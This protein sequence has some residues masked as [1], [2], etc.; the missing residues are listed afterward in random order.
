V[1]ARLRDLDDELLAWVGRGTASGAALCDTLGLCAQHGALLAERAEPAALARLLAEASRRALGLLADDRRSHERLTALVF[2]AEHACG[3]C[4]LRSH[5]LALEVH[6]IARDDPP[7]PVC[8]AHYPSLVHALNQS[9]LHRLVL[10]QRARWDELA[11]QLSADGPERLRQAAA[12]LGVPAP[13]RIG[14]DSECPVC[15]EIE[16]ARQRW[17]ASVGVA[18][19]IGEDM[20]TVFPVCPAHV[21]RCLADGPALAVARYAAGLR[22]RAL[23][24]AARAIEHDD[25]QRRIASASVFYRRQSAAYVLGLQRRMATAVPHCPGCEKLAVAQAHGVAGLID[26][27]RRPSAARRADICVKHFALAYLDAPPGAP[28][29]ALVAD[30]DASLRRHLDA[31]ERGGDEAA[32]QQALRAWRTAMP[33]PL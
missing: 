27:L 20:W 29:A 11:A 23:H 2:G 28:R 32:L 9:S 21:G 5:R 13:E 30:L 18:A 19:H 12:W 26:G 10:G 3:L 16:R 7:P 22:A 31:L 4:R 8:A 25:E 33:S 15:A 17:E 24:D 14:V 1:C 6:R